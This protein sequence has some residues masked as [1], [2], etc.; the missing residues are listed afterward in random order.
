MELEFHVISAK[1]MNVFLTKNYVYLLCLAAHAH[2][3]Q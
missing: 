2:V 1:M 3:S